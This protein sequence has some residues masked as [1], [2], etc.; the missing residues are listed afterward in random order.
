MHVVQ[1]EVQAAIDAY[2]PRALELHNAGMAAKLGL[3][4]FD[5]DV[6][7]IFFKLLYEAE[8]DF[9]NS[10]RAMTTASHASEFSEAPAELV[11]AFGKDLEETELSVC[12]AGPVYAPLG[13]AG[14]VAHPEMRAAL[15]SRPRW[16][17]CTAMREGSVFRK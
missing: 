13:V 6:V 4:E 10:F 14:S 11:A 2:G 3:P 15:C 7:S 5:E 1:P 17:Q 8:A 12:P 16:W 9:T